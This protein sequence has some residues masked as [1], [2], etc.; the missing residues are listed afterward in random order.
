[1]AGCQKDA[2]EEDQGFQLQS[3][4]SKSLPR[5][6]KEVLKDS[7]TSTDADVRRTSLAEMAKWKNPDDKLIELVGLTLLGD[8]EPLVRAQAARTLGAW[9]AKGGAAYLSKGLTGDMATVPLTR[10]GKP[11]VTP[12]MHVSDSNKF[13]RIDCAGALGEVPAE[14]AV[15]PLAE[16]L[17]FDPEADVRSAAARALEGHRSTGAANGLVA[18]LT[19]GDVAVAE[20]ARESLGYLTGRDLGGDPAAWTK[21]LAESKDPLARYGH[22]PK[23]AKTTAKEIDTHE[24]RKESVKQIFKDMFPLEKQEG[25]FD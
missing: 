16:A 1:M 6:H 4:I 18:G 10:E 13:V 3:F 22:A 15:K 23:R 21:F 19:D 25:P 17:R 5:P 14:E 9:K 8:N 12:Q 20:S 7:V 24:D 11:L 2:D